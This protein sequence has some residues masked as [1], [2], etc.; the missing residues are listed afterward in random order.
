M[1]TCVKCGQ[2]VVK[3]GWLWVL[4][5]EAASGRAS[6]CAGGD[7]IIHEVDEDDDEG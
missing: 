5:E 6:A 7:G 1:P 4:P 3:R 2:E